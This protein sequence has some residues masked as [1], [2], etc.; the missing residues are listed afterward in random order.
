MNNATF[1][2][3]GAAA[4]GL[5]VFSFCIYVAMNASKKKAARKSA[6]PDARES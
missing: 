4:I 2:A 5:V 6:P 3:L 1:I